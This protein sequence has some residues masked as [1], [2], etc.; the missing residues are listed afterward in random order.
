MTV[1]ADPCINLIILYM[2][3]GFNDEGA[4]SMVL[5]D[6]SHQL[7]VALQRAGLFTVNGQVHQRRA[8]DG[9]FAFLPEFFQLLLNVSDLNRTA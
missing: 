8:C 3:I 1:C 2:A 7:R 4:T 5:G 6:S 9:A